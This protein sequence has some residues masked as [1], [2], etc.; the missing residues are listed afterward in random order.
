MTFLHGL[1]QRKK[2]LPP[3]QHA[4]SEV[5]LIRRRIELLQ[6]LINDFHSNPV[7]YH[8]ALSGPVGEAFNQLILDKI[9]LEIQHLYLTRFF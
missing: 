9:K 4:L 6:L 3:E 7:K 1:F 5:E 2:Q 8:Q